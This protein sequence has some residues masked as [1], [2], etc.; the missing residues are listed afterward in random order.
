MSLLYEKRLDNTIPAGSFGDAE[1]IEIRT[2]MGSIVASGHVMSVMPFGLIVRESTGDTKFYGENLYLFASLEKD[3]P[4]IVKGQL[5]DT[6]LDA[7]VREKLSSM[8]EAGDPA[9]SNTG[10]KP[11]DKNATD[12]EYKDKDGEKAKDSGDKKDDKKPEKDDEKDDDAVADPDSSIDTENLPDD[13]KQAI[14]SAK[15]MDEGQLNSVLSDISDAALKALKRSGVADGELFGLV[16]KI[17]DSSFEVL[18]G[19]KPGKK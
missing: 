14:V 13:I 9:P 8:G 12:D 3:P 6:S 19:K 16:Q 2:K 10:A 5:L 17:S 11:I 4:T 1:G 15:D 18:T 7:R